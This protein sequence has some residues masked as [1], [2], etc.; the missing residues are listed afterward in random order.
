MRNKHYMQLMG[1]RFFN[2]LK[3]LRWGVKVVGIIWHCQKK[4]QRISL[5]R[6]SG[7][8]VSFLLTADR[9]CVTICFV[10]VNFP[11]TCDE[12][13]PLITENGHKRRIMKSKT[14]PRTRR[15]MSNGGHR[16]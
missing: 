5:F 3:I 9:V 1:G 12:L 10:S 2:V 4:L 14:S 13:D 15:H 8:R 16:D 7:F 11:V 6:L